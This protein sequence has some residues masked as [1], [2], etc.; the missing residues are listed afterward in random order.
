MNR[1]IICTDPAPYDPQTKNYRRQLDAET[2]TIEVVTDQDHIWLIRADLYPD[3]IR[4]FGPRKLAHIHDLMDL[5]RRWAETLDDWIGFMNAD[6]I[7]TPK[8]FATIQDLEHTEVVMVS[9]TDIDHIDDDPEVTGEKLMDGSTDA[10]FVRLGVWNEMGDNYP[11][12]IL[13]E[14][15]WGYGARSWAR[16]NNLEVKN[17]SSHECLHVRH[18]G[19]WKRTQGKGKG[20]WYN[21]KLYIEYVRGQKPYHPTI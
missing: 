7:L 15:A 6:L 4:R 14:P 2:R 17:L 19:E 1:L 3:L 8:F 20:Y 11:D 21:R 13:G 18:Y 10:L 5:S 12:Y 9:R 16:R